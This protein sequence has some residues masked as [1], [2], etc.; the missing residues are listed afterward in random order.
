[1]SQMASSFA[2]IAKACASPGLE[3][4]VLFG[5][6]VRA[7]RLTRAAGFRNVVAHAY[8]ELDMRRV[9]TAAQEGPR[10]LRA[11]LAAPSSRF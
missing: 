1:M 7:G 10:D 8:E 9:H 4:L 11:F 3:L 6:R 5:S 2:D